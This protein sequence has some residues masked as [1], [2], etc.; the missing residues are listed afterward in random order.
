MIKLIGSD[1]KAASGVKI[2]LPEEQNLLPNG[3]FS[4]K[5]SKGD[6]LKWKTSGKLSSKEH[7]EHKADSLLL[8]GHLAQAVQR[9]KVKPGEKYRIEGWVKSPSSKKQGSIGIRLLNYKWLL[10][11]HNR[12]DEWEHISGEFTV[13]EKTDTLY[14]YCLN[15]YAGKETAIH[16]ADIKLVK[17]D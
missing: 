14:V 13:P 3:D 5:N 1:G 9:F 10:R 15:W 8:V 6:I 4:Q 2:I 11:L 12:T 16:Y 7:P 17:V